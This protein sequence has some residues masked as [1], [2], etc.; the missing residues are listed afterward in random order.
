MSDDVLDAS[1]AGAWVA[2]FCTGFA[3]RAEELTA[4]DRLAGDGDFGDNLKAP[5]QRVAAAL[6][7]GN[8]P[9]TSAAE[10]FALVS[11]ELMRAGG[12]SGP[13]FGAFFRAVAKQG[14]ESAMSLGQLAAG[15]TAGASAVARLGGA[16]PGDSTMLDALL[17][18]A[19]ALEAANAR[20]AKLT[21]ALAGAAV[22][23]SDGAR[24]TA[25]MAARRGRASYLG[26]AAVGIVDPGAAA[27]ALLFE[28]ALLV[29]SAGAR[30][31]GR[32][33]EAGP[34]LQVRPV[35][36]EEHEAAGRIVLAAYEALPGGHLTGGY[37]EELLDVARRAT[38][39]EVFVALV[40]GHSADLDGAL[41]GCV[42]L[43]PDA[44]SAWAEMLEEGEAGIRMLAVLPAAQGRGVGRALVDACVA[45]ARELG[46]D[47]LMLHTTPWMPAAHRLYEQAGFERLPERDWL[48]VPEVPLLAYRL[49][50]D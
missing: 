27:V 28:S 41:V 34:A 38:E 22:A 42:T 9:P 18:A 46:K 33:A 8:A 37:A 17:P 50:L 7:G 43:V 11:S 21:E 5:L 36:A 35:R 12:T 31:A 32:R 48:P 26:D 19:A 15:V 30:A 1:R 47:A 29:E 6:A 10:V 39:A 13:L 49:V 20:H 23:A 2:R 16:T 14:G 25:A 24:A 40:A 4:L 45:R 44:R 3:E